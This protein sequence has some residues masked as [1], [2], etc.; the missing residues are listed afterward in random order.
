MAL[1]SGTSAVGHHGW[2]FVYYRGPRIL[3]TSHHVESG[4]VRYLVRDLEHITRVVDRRRNPR[5]ME[6]RAIHHGRETVLF[7]SRDQ[8]EFGQVRRAVIRAVEAHRW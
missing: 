6:L 2:V 1:T 7:R 4:G 3:V 8:R 5:W